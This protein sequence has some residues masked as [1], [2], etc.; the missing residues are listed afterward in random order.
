MR[1]FFFRALYLDSPNAITT[2][3]VVVAFIIRVKRATPGV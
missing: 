1:I 2:L 3:E